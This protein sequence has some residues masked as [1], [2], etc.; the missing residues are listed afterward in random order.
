MARNRVG[1][2]L[3]L[4]P[5]SLFSLA[6]RYDNPTRFLAPILCSKIPARDSGSLLSCLLFLLFDEPWTYR[7]VV[8]VVKT[9]KT[10]YAPIVMVAHRKWQKKICQP[11]SLFFD[12][13]QFSWDSIEYNF[14]EWSKPFIITKPLQDNRARSLRRS[15]AESSVKNQ[16]PIC[17]PLR[18]PGIDSQ[19]GGLVRQ[20]YLTSGS[21]TLSPAAPLPPSF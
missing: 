11:D 21:L 19:S 18:S 1:T 7:G 14:F 13:S 5:P 4:R 15:A 17:K 9:L 3:S 16:S 6:G 12:T 10:G 2:E 20:P 8:Y